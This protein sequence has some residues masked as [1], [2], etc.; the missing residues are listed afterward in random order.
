MQPALMAE[1]E[2]MVEQEEIDEM[3]DREKVGLAGG[4]EVAVSSVDRDPYEI[5]VRGQT[6]W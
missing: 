2:T 4:F 3:M 6:V 1:L 5:V